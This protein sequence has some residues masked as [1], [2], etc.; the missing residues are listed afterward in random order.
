LGDTPEQ[1]HLAV[2]RALALGEEPL[3]DGYWYVYNSSG[4]VWR[5]SDGTQL[6][7]VDEFI[8]GTPSNFAE[9]L[10]PDSYDGNGIWLTADLD[11][12]TDYAG[13][14]VVLGGDYQSDWHDLTS[15]TA[16]SFWARGFAKLRV[17]LVTQAVLEAHPEGDNW[18]HFHSE[19]QL[20]SEWTQFVVLAEDLRPKPFSLAAD[21][22]MTWDE[23]SDR[24]A[25]LDF[26]APPET[27]S[28]VEVALDEVR[29]HGVTY[30]SF[31]FTE[32]ELEA[33]LE[34]AQ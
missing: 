13:F 4:S 32:A 20:S 28:P 5:S 12:S 3:P 21:E 16:I 24:V 34:A 31:G 7:N 6:V 17:A 11:A 25:L 9:T 30:E 14:G 22:G 19:V 10:D 27:L 1:A 26:E 23:C 18:G 29:L 15:L 2:A 8:A 33:A